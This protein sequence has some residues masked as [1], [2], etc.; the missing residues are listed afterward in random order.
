[1]TGVGDGNGFGGDG[2]AGIDTPLFSLNLHEP[3]L[4]RASGTDDPHV[5][6]LALGGFLVLR[7]ADLFGRPVADRRATRYQIDATRDY[8]NDLLPEPEVDRLRE[9]VEAAEVA[10]QAETEDAVG[11]ALGGYAE[12]LAAD[13]RYDE[14]ADV[15]ETAAALVPANDVRHQWVQ[16]YLGRLYTR[17]RR[18]AEAERTFALAG[19]EG[20]LTGEYAVELESRI[21]C[22]MMLRARGRRR[23]AEPVLTE[24]VAA[25]RRQ[26]LTETEMRAR[27]GLAVVL[28]EGG[29]P[30]AGAAH[31]VAAVE[32]YERPVDRLQAL[33]DLG[34]MLWRGGSV[35]GA[36]VSW[37]TVLEHE[38]PAALR[39]QATAGLVELTAA[40]G[41]RL[42]FERW[43]REVRTTLEVA[44]ASVQVHTAV[45]LARGLASFGKV[46]E[47]KAMLGG[48]A[49]LAQECGVRR[50]QRRARRWLGALERGRVQDVV[51][52]LSSAPRGERAEVERVG[53]RL[54]R[55]V[56]R[57]AA[58]VSV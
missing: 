29:H 7:L 18:F 34:A 4:A 27:H 38:L 15:V 41:N 19:R 13:E 36:A 26:R 16:V 1:M 44:P 55:T 58:L 40:L 43:L 9:I 56:T 8:V 32:G 24:V 12:W 53:K 14:A 21:G 51:F 35:S 6:N 52:R 39:L 48:A 50:T 57:R 5:N 45:A 54:R 47:A 3:F 23:L 49:A 28:A 33:A 11:A 25:A 2:P 30:G 10:F 42:G 22:A 46:E 17:A 31:A 20:R 37:E